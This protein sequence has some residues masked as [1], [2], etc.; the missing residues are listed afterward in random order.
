MVDCPH[1]YHILAHLYI[2]TDHHPNIDFTTDRPPTTIMK[3]DTDAAGPDHNPILAD[4]KAEAT[5]T[6]TKAIPGHTTGTKDDITGVVHDAHTQVLIHFIL[7]AT[8]HTADHLHIGAL[9]L[10]PKTASDHN[11]NQPT[12][13]LRKAHSNLHHSPEDHKVKH[14]LKG[15]Q[16]LQ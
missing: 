15:I 6:P 16:E 10:T 3:A 7:N 5:M 11:L 1:E 12:N 8:L 9:Q 14:I 4:T 13:Q 2:T